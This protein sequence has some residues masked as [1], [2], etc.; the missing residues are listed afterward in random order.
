MCGI[1][2][3][4]SLAGEPARREDLRAIN[5]LQAHRGPDDSGIYVDGALGLAHTRLSILD[6]SDA[7]KQPMHF[8]DRYVLTFNGEIYNFLELRKTLES[9][10]CRFSSNSD[11]EVILAAYD[12]WGEDCQ[13]RFN[14]M[15]AFAIWDRQEQ[16]LFMSRDRFGVKLFHYFF[17]GDNFAFASEMK[18]F[19]GLHFFDLNFDERI[20]TRAINDFNSIEASDDC[21]LKGVRR[22]RA[23]HCLTLRKDGGARLRRWWNTLDHIGERTTELAAQCMQ[24][25]EDFLDA[26]TIRM[27]SDVPLATALSG[28]LDSSSV[29]SAI[30]HIARTQ[31]VGERWPEDW[32]RAFVAT[33]PGSAQDEREFAEAV[34]AHTGASAL[35][36]IIDP[37]D[38]ID[39]LDQILFDVEDIADILS[40]PWLLYRELR[41]AGAVISM[42]GHGGDELFAGY[43]HQ[44]KV[45]MDNA[46]EPQ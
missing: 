17:D 24:F 18:G 43:H 35:Y 1:A 10:G 45:A 12:R 4:W 19:L 33:F 21:L 36:K 14:G 5:V 8:A 6:L 46:V 25:R 22:L 37:G 2:G 28:G 27:R 7:G 9:R 20:L 32:Q 34:V 38:A 3:V 11:S 42:D 23:G 26:C 44:V 39:N 16:T 30:S 40:G 15:W 41:R 29:H 31:S 13:N